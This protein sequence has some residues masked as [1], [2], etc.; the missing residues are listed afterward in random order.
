MFIRILTADGQGAS[1]TMSLQGR[2]QN[3]MKRQGCFE[4]V[5]ASAAKL[6]HAHNRQASRAERPIL[7][8]SKSS[9]SEL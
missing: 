5:L 9:A 2:I 7:A 6:T 8:C 1:S 4:Y 3:L